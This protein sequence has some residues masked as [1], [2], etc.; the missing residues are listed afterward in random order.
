MHNDKNHDVTDKDLYLKLF[1]IKTNPN[2]QS[3]MADLWEMFTSPK[4]GHSRG[5]VQVTCLSSDY[6]DANEQGCIIL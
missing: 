6:I 1:I 5:R 3:T 4:C 2:V